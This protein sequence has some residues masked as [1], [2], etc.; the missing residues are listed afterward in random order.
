MKPRLITPFI[1]SSRKRIVVRIVVLMALLFA[2][3]LNTSFADGPIPAIKFYPDNPEKSLVLFLTFVDG[4][5]LS[6]DSA[7]V[8]LKPAGGYPDGRPDVAV[9]VD[10]V[11]SSLIGNFTLPSPLRMR[12]YDA[13]GADSEKFQSTTQS[14]LHFP[15]EPD[16]SSATISDNLSDSEVTVDLKPIIH[17]FCVGHLDDPE[18][19]DSDI[20]ISSVGAVDP[21]PLVLLGKSVDLTVRSI[22]DNNGPEAKPAPPAEEKGVDALFDQQVTNVSQGI[23]VAPSEVTGQQEFGLKVEVSRT[24][25][26][27]YAVTCLEPGMQEAT[28]TSTIEPLS[29]AVIEPHEVDTTVASNNTKAFVLSVDCAVPVTLNNKPHSFPNSVNLEKEGDI[30]VAV[31]TTEQGEYGNPLAFDAQTIDPSTVHYGVESLASYDNGATES[32]EATHIKDSYELDDKTR[33]KDLDA[34]MHFP[35]KD[36]GLSSGDTETCIKGKFTDGGN[37]FTF[38]GCD[39]VNV[40]E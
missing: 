13:D 9:E 34:V 19:Y 18:C 14:A 15:F 17:D 28:F 27:T 25:D 11:Y 4:G 2:M 5:V 22:I 20:A 29:A 32:H 39:S 24:N 16:A 8:S 3:P 26:Q 40:I 12:V 10:D 30:P 7:S 38:F 1:E 33:D 35:A 6:Y 36:T 31:L 23:T 21:P 37:T